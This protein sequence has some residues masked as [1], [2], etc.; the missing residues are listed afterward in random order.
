MAHTARRV[1]LVLRAACQLYTMA[2]HTPE[3][4][5]L[6]KAALES[7]GQDL[8][9]LPVCAAQTLW[10]A[11]LMQLAMAVP[12][13][14]L[15]FATATHDDCLLSPRALGTA[16]AVPLCLAALVAQGAKPAHSASVT[17]AGLHT[18]LAD[19]VSATTRQGNAEA[20][21]QLADVATSL[22]L[23]YE[24]ATASTELDAVHMVGICGAVTAAV[25]ACTVAGYPAATA[26]LV[27]FTAAKGEQHS[28]SMVVLC[29]WLSS[30]ATAH[31]LGEQLAHV[32]QQAAASVSAQ[33]ASGQESL[34]AC[35][36][37]A[38]EVAGGTGTPG[39]RLAAA[40]ITFGDA[41][42]AATLNAALL[43][44]VGSGLLQVP[45]SALHALAQG[46]L[47]WATRQHAALHHSAAPDAVLL[48]ANERQWSTLWQPQA[49]NKYLDTEELAREALARVPERARAAA[50]L[51]RRLVVP[52]RGDSGGDDG[53]AA[54]GGLNSGDTNAAGAGGGAGAGAGA[55]DGAGPSLHKGASTV[56][57]PIVS[58]PP[59]SAVTIQAMWKALRCNVTAALVGS[60]GV[61]LAIAKR[62]VVCCVRRL[63]SKARSTELCQPVCCIPRFAPPPSTCPNSTPLN[64]TVDVATCCML[65]LP[66]EPLPRCSRQL[67]ST[68]SAR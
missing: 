51:A 3:A 27:G 60:E 8:Q 31:T 42:A 50:Q 35:V 57:V 43:S 66:I 28:N 11:Q 20:L 4:A 7:L 54:A 55:T 47:A 45:C 61:A 10:Q 40:A 24:R 30:D 6:C 1:A 56:V 58:C 22:V 34:R 14:R 62:R 64:C 2:P 67:Q 36:Q 37:A 19:V 32:V 39:G 65:S 17:L 13:P 46:M 38:E 48:E 5:A 44:H 18:V 49:G 23:A 68:A 21:W 41:Y 15:S 25:A 12:P 16:T 29:P 59:A 26:D 9:A 52:L 63:Y 33:A 53:G